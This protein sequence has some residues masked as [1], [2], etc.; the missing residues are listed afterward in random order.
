MLSV[1]M[2]GGCIRQGRGVLQKHCL[3]SYQL[4]GLILLAP[5]ETEAQ[6]RDE[7]ALRSHLAR[8]GGRGGLGTGRTGAAAC[9]PLSLPSRTQVH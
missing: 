8:S 7:L 3:L 4:P 2:G 5:G 6:G 1:L 9:G